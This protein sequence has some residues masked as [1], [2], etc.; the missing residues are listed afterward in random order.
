MRRPRD[1]RPEFLQPAGP[2]HARSRVGALASSP[3]LHGIIPYREGIPR[4]DFQE[5]SPNGNGC[6]SSRALLSDS[7]EAVVNT[8]P[9]FQR[10]LK[11]GGPGGEN[12]GRPAQDVAPLT[13]VLHDGYIA[14]VTFPAVASGDGFNDASAVRRQA[15]ACHG[16][17]RHRGHPAGLG[18]GR[19]RRGKGF[20]G[21]GPGFS[22]DRPPRRQRQRGNP[23]GTRNRRRRSSRNTLPGAVA[24][25]ADHGVGRSS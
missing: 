24:W 23:S 11:N 10:T 2:G 18:H 5:I 3:R 6:L 9:I 17:R 4:A 21:S 7:S 15:S 8:M 25:P 14:S 20:R 12:P 19:H 22:S 1:Q 16:P 13:R